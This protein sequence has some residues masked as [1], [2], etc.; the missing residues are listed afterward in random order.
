MTNGCKST[1]VD[2]CHNDTQSYF[3]GSYRVDP[4]S[5]PGDSPLHLRRNVR[6]SPHRRQA[7][8]QPRRSSQR[9]QAARTARPASQPARTRLA[10]SP[11]PT[12]STS[13]QPRVILSPPSTHQN[14]LEVR[15]I[16]CAGSTQ[17][18][19]R[20]LHL[21]LATVADLLFPLAHHR[22]RLLRYPPFDR[23]LFHSNIPFIIAGDCT[24]NSLTNART[25][26]S[27][28][29]G[30]FPITRCAR[31][32]L[33]QRYTSTG[34]PTFTRQSSTSTWTRRRSPSSRLRSASVRTYP[35]KDGRFCHRREE[36]RGDERRERRQAGGW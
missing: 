10:G 8:S 22:H 36:Q 24:C 30:P 31:F 27:P 19:A 3:A 21:D 29:C 6:P 2:K 33:S 5:H 25:R 28:Y 9:S 15:T 18:T 26:R 13:S 12:T 11:P 16:I 34:A 20:T 35:L 4:A 1:R 7:A 17:H 14:G 23:F 32:P